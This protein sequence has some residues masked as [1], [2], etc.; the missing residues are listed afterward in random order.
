[1]KRILI[2]LTGLL[3]A[4]SGFSQTTAD[5]TRTKKVNDQNVTDARLKAYLSLSL[6]H[7]P[8]FTLNGAKDSVGYIMFNTTLNRIGVYQ[9]GGIWKQYVTLDEMTAF[10]ADKVDKITGK[11]LI[12]DSEISRLL[13][14][15]PVSSA[16]S[17]IGVSSG[18]LT[19]NSG[20][21]ANQLVKRDSDG[22]LPTGNIVS[23]FRVDGE[24]GSDNMLTFRTIIPGVG[25][26]NKWAVM[27]DGAYNF[28]FHNYNNGTFPFYLDKTSDIASFLVS[29]TAPTPTAGSNNT[30][31]ATTAFVSNAVGTVSDAKVDIVN[32]SIRLASIAALEAYSGTASSIVIPDSLRG[33]N[34]HYVASGLVANGGTVFSATGKGSGFWQRDIS[35]SQGYS[36]KWFGAKGDWNMITNTGTDDKAAIQACIDSRPNRNTPVLFPSGV[37][38]CSDSLVVGEGTY[39]KGLST[40]FPQQQFGDGSIVTKY[41]NMTALKF[42]NATNGIVTTLEAV[43]YRSQGIKIEGLGIFGSSKN[44]GKTGVL[45]RQTTNSTFAVKTTGLTT[46]NY[47]YFSDWGVGAS[48]ASSTD[49]WY[50]TYCHFSDVKVGFIGGSGQTF[51]SHTDL[52]K[53]DSIGGIL[54]S[55]TDPDYVTGGEVE[56]RYANTTAI[57]INGRAIIN[58][59]QFLTNKKSIVFGASAGQS[60]ISGNH[61]RANSD[62]DI[63]VNTAKDVQIIGN[64]FMADYGTNTVYNYNYVLEPLNTS[65]RLVYATNSR[66]QINSNYFSKNNALYTG[67]PVLIDNSTV[68]ASGN[69]FYLFTNTNEAQFAYTG[70]NIK[71]ENF[72]IGNRQ[73]AGN[74]ITT[75]TNYTTGRLSSG[76]G[77]P[78]TLLGLGQIT[79]VGNTEDAGSLASE[80]YG[81]APTLRFYGATG[82]QST[83]GNVTSGWVIG[84]IK[85]LG[86]FG[87]FVTRASIDFTTTETWGATNKGTKIAFSVTPTGANARVE[88]ANLS[89]SGFYF[90]AGNTASAIVHIKAGTATASTAPLKFTAGTNLTTPE[91]GALEFD[92]TNY[93]AT[94]STTRYTLAKTLTATGTL[95]FASTAAQNSSELT[96]TVTGASDG[97]AV[98]VGVPNAASSANTCFTARVSASNTVT[99]KFNNY[100]AGA[101]DP[102]SAS[103]RVSV[104]KY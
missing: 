33:G 14:I 76:V 86:Y 75:G 70:T 103:F 81:A 22:R 74:N 52:F 78:A 12:A 50:M 25:T 60:I 73:T 26:S 15:Y 47:C 101:I 1:M 77:Q 29:P 42:Y 53:I 4:S 54:N 92:G 59:T 90:G 66:V 5:Y 97:D 93:F 32:A 69:V 55:A 37:Y 27:A 20:T 49:S 28:A 67:N 100:S 65:R 99:I 2:F 71:I 6:P 88:L 30:K 98:V 80:V 17:D 89:G 46:T 61:F 82:T 64:T 13:T 23:P 48:G 43:S 87:G 35:N 19:L 79:A 68:S 39:L 96:I 51:V 38:G 72:D 7:F 36:V 94:S 91:A 63:T 56:T 31:L 8:T 83:P 16:N 85:A 9:G 95:D 18:V 44:N 34:F 84:Q 10:L 40:L 3:F 24:L 45:F 102:A 41:K 62:D 21:G 11:S 104:L 57:L 58:G